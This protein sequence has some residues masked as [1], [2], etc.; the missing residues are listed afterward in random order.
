VIDVKDFDFLNLNGIYIHQSKGVLVELWINNPYN[1]IALNSDHVFFVLDDVYLYDDFNLL[2][3]LEIQ[4]KYAVDIIS[5]SIE[6]SQY[7]YF[8]HN[9]HINEFIRTNILEFFCYIMSPQTFFKYLS[10]VTVENPSTCGND[11]LMYQQGL[12]VG[13]CM[14]TKAVH[15]IKA[16]SDISVNRYAILVKLL[17]TYGYDTYLEF[18][19]TVEIIL[20]EYPLHFEMLNLPNI[21]IY[22]KKITKHWIYHYHL[23]KVHF[24]YYD[25]DEELK[26]IILNSDSTT[27]IICMEC[28]QYITDIKSFI[29]DCIAID[30]E[31]FYYSSTCSVWVGG[32]IYTQYSIDILH[33]SDLIYPNKLIYSMYYLE[34]EIDIRETTD[35]IGIILENTSLCNYSGEFKE[36]ENYD[37]VLIENRCCVHTEKTFSPI[38]PL[39]QNTQL[40]NK[41]NHSI[42]IEYSEFIKSLK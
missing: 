34:K 26:D 19:N 31:Y 3:C 20:Y 16:K 35:T 41:I 18:I 30:S 7:F 12:S 11:L 1:Y 6:N 2:K 33:Q 4:A 21:K 13:V 25:N 32:C 10:I 39:T 29:N 23:N 22:C 15:M 5:P 17:N 24:N 40:S 42:Y 8:K 9:H 36:Y 38:H 27:K 14:L 37:S 28:P